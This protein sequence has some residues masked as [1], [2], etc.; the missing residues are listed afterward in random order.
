MA[1]KDLKPT[2]Q[3]VLLFALVPGCIHETPPSV[4][5]SGVSILSPAPMPQDTSTPDANLSFRSQLIQD[6]SHDF[7]T[8]EATQPQPSLV[9]SQ[10]QGRWL[11]RIQDCLGQDHLSKP[12]HSLSDRIFCIS[13]LGREELQLK[14]RPDVALKNRYEALLQDALKMTLG[15]PSLEYPG[16][17]KIWASVWSNALSGD[18]A[19]RLPEYSRKIYIKFL[20][21]AGDETELNKSRFFPAQIQ[22]LRKNLANARVAS[23]PKESQ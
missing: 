8:Q 3:L 10:T 7:G 18:D 23:S 16:M 13:L 22:K 20:E 17:N 2:L 1:Q 6:W 21:A 11:D 19:S 12:I 5:Q 9:T 15:D 4:S 14:D